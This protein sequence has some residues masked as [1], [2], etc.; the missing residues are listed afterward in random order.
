MTFEKYSYISLCNF[1]MLNQ[2]GNKSAAT[3][4]NWVKKEA[5]LPF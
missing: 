2:F 4:V 5:M 3:F 1:T